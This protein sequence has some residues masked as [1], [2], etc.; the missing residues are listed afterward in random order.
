PVVLKGMSKDIVHKT[1]AGVVKLNISNSQELTKAYD[2]IVKNA[3]NYNSEVD[4]AGILVQEMASKG[5]ELIFGVKKDP[6]FGYQLIVGFGG[7]LVE[8]M[9]D[10]TMRMMPVSEQDI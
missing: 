9:K 2:D 5:I 10:F 7:T 8:I 4:I 6:V 3:I 1:E